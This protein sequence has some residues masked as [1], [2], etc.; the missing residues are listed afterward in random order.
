[1]VMAV[2]AVVCGAVVCWWRIGAVVCR[3]WCVGRWCVGGGGSAV[4][5]GAAV[6][7][8]VCVGGG[9][10]GGGAWGGGVWPVVCGR[11]RVGQLCGASHGGLRDVNAAA[12]LVELRCAVMV[13]RN[14]MIPGL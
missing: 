8:A 6:R 7:G 4:V 11:W 12:G 2:V 3:R 13:C 1:M 14:A 9:G 5:C 10:W